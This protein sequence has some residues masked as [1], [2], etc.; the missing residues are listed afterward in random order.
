MTDHSTIE[1][2]VLRQIGWDHW[3]PV[4]IRQTD[5]PA[6]RTAA[7]DEYDSYLLHAAGM[8]LQS[9]SQE[10]VAAYLDDITVINMGLG[11]VNGA[12]HGASVRTADAIAAYLRTRSNDARSSDTRDIR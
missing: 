12:I 6:W 1:M 9:A 5:D 2:N 4:G 10:A 11:P 3:D 8:V 7:A